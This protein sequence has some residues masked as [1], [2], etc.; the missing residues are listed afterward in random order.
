MNLTNDVPRLTGLQARGWEGLSPTVRIPLEALGSD[1]GI[2][3]ML[4]D[5]TGTVVFANPAW[6]RL[7]DVPQVTGHTVTE[8]LGEAMAAERQQIRDRVLAS[9]NPESILD[10]VGGVLLRTTRRPIDSAEDGVH[11]CVLVT[12]CVLREG[13]DVAN[14]PLAAY[15]DLGRLLSLTEREIELLHHVGKGLSSDVAATMMHRS[16]RTVEWHRASLG[17]KLGCTNRVELARVALAAGITAVSVE[18]LLKI[19]RAAKPR[20]A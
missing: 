5:A 8:L 3:T 4:V 10:M 15:H 18:M 16:I 17:E 6:N 9:K 2:L 20:R 14:L 1:A 12:S 7:L 19:H 11:D 13:M